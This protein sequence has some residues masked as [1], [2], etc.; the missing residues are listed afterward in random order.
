[1]KYK[2]Y[3]TFLIDTRHEESVTQIKEHLRYWPYVKA[4]ADNGAQ[5]IK[6]RVCI[7]QV[8]NPHERHH[9]VSRSRDLILSCLRQYGV[10]VLPTGRGWDFFRHYKGSLFL[11]PDHL[12]R[13]F[14]T[15]IDEI[16]CAS[17][18]RSTF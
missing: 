12:L 14:R 17:T 13:D 5:C 3:Q 6:V 2:H 10:A 18:K 16:D 1:M 8:N 7:G 4:F 15:F 9:Y 11:R